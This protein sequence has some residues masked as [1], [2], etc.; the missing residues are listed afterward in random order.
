M[1]FNIGVHIKKL[2]SSFFSIVGIAFLKKST[3]VRLLENEIEYVKILK[4]IEFKNKYRFSGF[5][6]SILMR[7]EEL[8]PKS[9]AQLQQDIVCLM[10]LNFKENGFFVEFGAT[11]GVK[12]SNSYLLENDF[13]WRGIL[14]EPGRNWH[15]KLK[16]NRKSIIETRCVYRHTGE[17]LAFNETKVGELSTIHHY[18]FKDNHSDT[19]KEGIVY[20]VETI[21]LNDLLA[22]NNAPAHIDYLSIDTEGSEYEI[23]LGV[24]FEK[25]TF[26]F[27]TC[28]HNFTSNRTLIYD[29]L[30]SKGYQRVFAEKSLYDDWYVHQSILKVQQFF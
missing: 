19:R 25:Y 4:L 17:F 9:M 5:D 10:F 16:S 22:Q 13:K 3:L 30:T 27:I 8:I 6:E 15:E 1:V 14:A 11:D 24:D 21:S 23:L 18:S 2:I 7:A 26:R 20:D 12:L 28:E 29:L